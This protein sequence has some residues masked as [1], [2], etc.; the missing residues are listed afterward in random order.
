MTA[1][2]ALSA[3]FLAGCTE[4]Y[5]TQNTEQPPADTPESS[6][7][8]ISLIDEYS[9]L[10]WNDS[11]E[12]VCAA[13]DGQYEYEIV[14]DSSDGKDMS[15]LSITSSKEYHGMSVQKLLRFEQLNAE[16]GEAVLTSISY[17]FDDYDGIYSY[18][19]A[20]LGEPDNNGTWYGPKLSEIYTDDEITAAY[21]SR[22]RI[23]LE[24]ELSREAYAERCAETL[25][26]KNI[27]GQGYLTDDGS[28][29]ALFSSLSENE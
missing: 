9:G 24:Q 6:S 14:N 15:T 12:D 1:S 13:L 18:L 17:A 21:N 3:L 25:T 22:E 28:Y 2:L 19:T 11:L 4:Q 29:T 20:E 8:M 5:R 16:T 26:L 23:G 27:N 10:D 7:E